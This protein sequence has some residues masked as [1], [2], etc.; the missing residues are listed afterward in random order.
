MSFSRSLISKESTFVQSFDEPQSIFRTLG[1]GS[2]RR[3]ARSRQDWI[4]Y[5]SS[6]LPRVAGRN[7]STNGSTAETDATRSHLNHDGSVRKCIDSGEATGQQADCAAAIGE[8]RAIEQ[9]KRGIARRFPL[10]DSFGQL[11]YF[12]VRP[13]LYDSIGCGGWI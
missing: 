9:G 4:S 12:H 3:E 6:H 1:P 7:R 8:R 13:Q 2:G 10:K 5:V 11:H